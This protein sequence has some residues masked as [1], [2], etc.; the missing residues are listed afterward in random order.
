MFVNNGEVTYIKCCKVDETLASREESSTSSDDTSVESKSDENNVL[1]LPNINIE[2]SFVT[3][4]RKTPPTPDSEK[5]SSSHSSSLERV[6]DV[7]MS[8]FDLCSPD[9]MN[10]LEQ[11]QAIGGLGSIFSFI[12]NSLLRNE[13]EGS[14][15]SD[16][17]Y[18]DEVRIRLYKL[19]KFK[20]KIKLVLNQ[21]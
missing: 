7:D 3:E 20:I 19:E 12:K 6:S 9:N 13:K 17:Q 14:K 21:F 2:E 10:I 4:M 18:D 16:D 11:Q 15:S 1:A 5:T 8:Q